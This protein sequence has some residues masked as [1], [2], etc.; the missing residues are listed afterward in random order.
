VSAAAPT[1]LTGLLPRRGRV[2]LIGAGTEALGVSLAL[3]GH[4]CVGVL[5]EPEAAALARD[6]EP[7]LR[8]VEGDADSLLLPGRAFD[9]AVLG[10]EAVL[11]RSRRT[12]VPALARVAWHLGASG[13]LAAGFAPTSTAYGDALPLRDYDRACAAADLAYEARYA[14]W[15]AARFVAGG[16]FAVSVHRRR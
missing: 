6:A 4:H 12:L 8:W 13:R 15:S 14:D 7:L 9:L 3:R 10:E 11:A 5:P 1:L 16:C 2:L